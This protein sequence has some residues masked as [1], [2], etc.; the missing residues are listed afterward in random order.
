VVGLVG[1]VG[2]PRPLSILWPR[3]ESYSGLLLPSEIRQLALDLKE[4]GSPQESVLE[5]PSL[6]ALRQLVTRAP[7]LRGHSAMAQELN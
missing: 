6:L 4:M 5:L 1:V 2:R 7:V 3:P